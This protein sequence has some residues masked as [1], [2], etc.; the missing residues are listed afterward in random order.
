MLVLLSFLFAMIGGVIAVWVGGGTLSLGSIIGFVT[1]VGIAVRNGIMMVSH[2]RHL[3]ADEQM[4]FGK[5]LVIRGAE[6]RLAPILMTALTAAL[7]LM[8][9][10]ITG[11]KPGHEIEYPMALVIGGGLLSS[12]M[13]NLFFMPSL[14]CAFGRVQNLSS[15]VIES[16]VESI[17]DEA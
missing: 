2:F 16:E 7:A 14:Y 15:A 13:M 1:V 17:E 3:E 9:L 10:V 11:N 4:S 12:T 5:E 8:P 6:E